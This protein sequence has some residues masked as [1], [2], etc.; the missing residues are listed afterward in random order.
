MAPLK[1]P[2]VWLRAYKHA[3]NRGYDQ[4]AE[5]FA[6]EC[7]MK[8]QAGRNASVGQIFIDYLRQRYGRTSVKK[9]Y[10]TQQLINYEQLN[11]NAV[12]DEDPKK[13][14][15]RVILDVAHFLEGE[16]RIIFIL[17]YI[18]GFSEPEIGFCFGLTMSA[19]SLRIKAIHEVL[20]KRVK[21]KTPTKE[22]K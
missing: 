10:T 19:I 5:D 16:Q 21:N 22:G 20:A 15:Q 4:D 14:D 7:Y 17:R 1:K 18:W 2:A 12:V 6:Q 11:D 9:P 13:W 3:V 8:I